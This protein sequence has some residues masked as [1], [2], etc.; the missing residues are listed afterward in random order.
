MANYLSATFAKY[1]MASVA[2]INIISVVHLATR[3]AYSVITHSN[4]TFSVVHYEE[5]LYR[6]AITNKAIKPINNHSLNK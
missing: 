1:A 6:P 5:A 2:Y 3:R 4:N